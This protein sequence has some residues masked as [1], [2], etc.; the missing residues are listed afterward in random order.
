MA[1]LFGRPLAFGLLTGGSVA[2]CGASAALAIAAVLPKRVIGEG[3]VLFTVVGVTALSTIAMVLYPV[4]YAALGVKTSLAQMFAQGPRGFPMIGA[5]TLLLL[6]MAGN[7]LAE[8]L[9]P[10]DPRTT[11]MRAVLA[12][13]PRR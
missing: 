4:L 6:A 9:R 2:I 8:P 3:D 11:A 7:G 5:E 1:R 13:S 12:P 10:S